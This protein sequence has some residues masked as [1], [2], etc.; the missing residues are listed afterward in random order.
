MLTLLA[1]KPHAY[2]D[3][4]ASE[5]WIERQNLFRSDTCMG[6]R[7]MKISIVN[8]ENLGE[9]LR[10]EEYEDVFELSALLCSEYWSPS[11]FGPTFVR[12][13][14]N[15]KSCSLL[16]LD[17]DRDCSLENAKEKFKDY[18]HIIATTRSHRR[19]KNGITCDR[20][21]VVIFLDGECTN[22]SDYTATWAAAKLKWDFV[23]GACKDLARFY[24]PCILD[25]I[26]RLKMG[27]NFK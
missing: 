25:R 24:Y 11:N 26:L 27:R 12:S 8:Q 14:E 18:E 9:I 15:F 23:D 17:V 3:D 20:F 16:V 7:Y 19:D 4:K 6:K 22:A 1:S 5:Y 13:N 21:R 2:V 10:K